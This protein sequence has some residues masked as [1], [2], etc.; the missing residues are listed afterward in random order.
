MMT[1]KQTVGNREKGNG[2][3]VYRSPRLQDYGS[4]RDLVLVKGA[5]QPDLPPTNT[6][7]NAQQ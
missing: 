6:K 5:G 3:R 4:L 1:A 2:R 7:Q